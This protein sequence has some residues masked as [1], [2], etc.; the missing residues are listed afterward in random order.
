MELLI[1]KN[2]FSDSY[3]FSMCVDESVLYSLGA[4][5]HCLFFIIT[6]HI[7]FLVYTLWNSLTFCIVSNFGWNILQ[8]YYCY[9]S[10]SHVFVVSTMD[11]IIVVSFKYDNERDTKYLCLFI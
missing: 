8:H 1:V 5:D 9:G 7:S 6:L 2:F 10:C 11:C 4:P 3:P